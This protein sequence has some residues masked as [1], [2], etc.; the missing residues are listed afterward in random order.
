MEMKILILLLSLFL[1]HSEAQ[2]NYTV[3]EL[4]PSSLTSSKGYWQFNS[5]VYA[6]GTSSSSGS[7]LVS[8]SPSASSNALVWNQLS[9]P[10]IDSSKIS[11]PYFAKGDQFYFTDSTTRKPT[12][13][14]SSV[15][16][17]PDK[18][19][20][21]LR[22]GSLALFEGA[23]GNIK[24]R[25]GVATDVL[26]SDELA[27]T[28]GSSGEPKFV[29]GKTA[30]VWELNNGKF[31]MFHD[32]STWQ[33]SIAN[34]GDSFTVSW[35]RSPDFDNFSGACEKGTGEILSTSDSNGKP[36]L[37][38]PPQ[39]PVLFGRPNTGYVWFYDGLLW[40]FQNE[41]LTFAAPA[42]YFWSDSIGNVWLGQSLDS[43]NVHSFPLP[44]AIPVLDDVYVP[45]QWISCIGLSLDASSVFD[46]LGG[47]LTFTWYTPTN[48]YKGVSV[49]LPATATSFSLTLTVNGT[50]SNSKT[51]TV[52][53]SS[54]QSIMLY[55]GPP[56]I[57]S[58]SRDDNDEDEDV[59]HASFFNYKCDGSFSPISKPI[60][61]TSNG[62]IKF[63]TGATRMSSASGE[64]PVAV[65]PYV[66]FGSFFPV[67]DIQSFVA[68]YSSGSFY[69]RN[70]LLSSLSTPYPTYIPVTYIPSAYTRGFSFVI[71]YHDG[72]PSDL[73]PKFL[74]SSEV[75]DVNNDFFLA[76]YIQSK[77]GPIYIGMEDN[78]DLTFK[79]SSPQFPNLFD[80]SATFDD[81]FILYFLDGT[82]QEGQSYEFTC[83]V[84]GSVDSDADFVF[85]QTYHVNTAS[86]H[87]SG[88][89]SST[90]NPTN[91]GIQY[92][93]RVLQYFDL[94]SQVNQFL[95]FYISSKDDLSDAN[96]FLLSDGSSNS[97]EGIVPPSAQ[98]YVKVSASFGYFTV[99]KD[100]SSLE[101]TTPLDT[102]A[103]AT[104]IDTALANQ[105]VSKALQL[106]PVLLE[107]LAKDN[108]IELD[109]YDKTASQL[110]TLS[111][112]VNLT[113][114]SPERQ[115]YIYVVEKMYSTFTNTDAQLLIQLF[116][117]TLSSDT[118]VDR[119]TGQTVF[120]AL[121]E[122]IVGSDPNSNA[123]NSLYLSQTGVIFDPM[124]SILT[125]TI[126][127]QASKPT[128]SVPIYYSAKYISAQG[129]SYSVKS[130]K[131][132]TFQVPSSNKGEK[133]PS[134][135]LPT[136]LSRV[137]NLS[138]VYVQ[139]YSLSFNPFIYYVPTDI[140]YQGVIFTNV[141][142]LSLFNSNGTV[143]DTK[144]ANSEDSS[145]V[146]TIRIPIDTNVYPDAKNPN[147]IFF[148]LYWNPSE[149]KMGNDGMFPNLNPVLSSDGYINCTSNH[150]TNF[151]VAILPVGVV[152][153]KPKPNLG[154]LIGLPIAAAV[155]L[156]LVLAAAI[157]YVRRKSRIYKRRMRETE[158]LMAKNA[159][160]S[161]FQT[162]KP[163]AIQ[164][165][166]RIGG[167]AFGDVFKGIYLGTTEVALK[168]LSDGADTSEFEQEADMLQRLQ[169][170]NVTQFLGIWIT[171]PNPTAATPAERG[172]PEQY[173]VIEFMSKGSLL[174][175]LRDVTDRPTVD[176][177]LSMCQETAAG[178]NYLADRGVVHRDLAARNL[179]V[180]AEGRR[181]VVKVADFGMSRVTDDQALYES[182]S[183]KFP[184][185][186][187]SPEI[188]EYRKYSTKSDVWAF[189]IV[190][191]ELF[192]Y[193]KI[194][195]PEMTNAEASERVL[196][197]YRLPRP[198]TCPPEVYELMLKCWAQEA[199][200]RPSFA[201]LFRILS[202]LLVARGNLD[203]SDVEKQFVPV[204]AENDI[205]NNSA[206]A[207]EENA[208]AFTDRRDPN[209]TGSNI[210]NAKSG[211]QNVNISAGK[212]EDIYSFSND[213]V[214]NQ[215]A[216]TQVK[217]DD[218][219]SF[220][221]TANRSSVKPLGRE[222]D[223]YS[224]GDIASR[225]STTIP[226]KKDSEFVPVNSVQED[227]YNSEALPVP[228]QPKPANPKE[229]ADSMY[230][231]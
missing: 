156:A 10:T 169:H 152:S 81:S 70:A 178:M 140:N 217:Q 58:L 99:L 147:A 116:N 179:L 5:T 52:S 189:G 172:E 100:S 205:Y 37:Y 211:I 41:W 216:S 230:S 198:A 173:M 16:N 25:I 228:S 49:T 17:A 59:E 141:T 34:N 88:S 40:Q 150:L 29:S 61:L 108:N 231:L 9:S 72:I 155:L 64:V 184:V 26:F 91:L 31:L 126:R 22:D 148:C 120:R 105:Q 224:Y 27:L 82:F 96:A 128:E 163:D 56:T 180:R 215:R 214:D 194:P 65:S 219:Y 53:V 177:I 104:A 143:L 84:S 121:N 35:V 106:F 226:P 97:F 63:P 83:L 1:L 110:I 134:I 221:D 11:S 139:H 220:G 80:V 2:K 188:L 213:S 181:Y 133:R 79:W 44:S 124:E 145:A 222:E 137:G 51:W 42:A 114:N 174:S 176:G 195:Y 115:N 8:L 203:P 118:I 67:S 218:F 87:N 162:I 92:N 71:S 170:P 144:P 199:N 38:C 18:I 12:L 135:T 45:D 151:T 77:S 190:M 187:S 225:S 50:L 74:V 207:P 171:Y 164:I 167:G 68:E 186:W 229:E 57:L 107:S 197:G 60:R 66:G 185:K 46:P 160:T 101:A 24:V 129:G 3:K 20:A 117:F 75:V 127:S 113:A 94:Y 158:E 122:I 166:H 125:K 138:D 210:Y 130:L 204:S 201:E 136:D 193:G 21:S 90:T 93:G 36:F 123:G 119:K 19:L 73:S 168:K 85:A 208:Y 191:W 95:Y 131:G 62:T 7:F 175:V 103:I 161:N 39:D 23:D 4:V 102:S 206:L 132:K 182:K 212:G 183:N 111:S 98:I 209:S 192:E 13:L 196:Q 6:L 112:L 149:M 69:T 14:S 202:N 200:E 153:G 55:R 109:V 15:S 43:P 165:L 54:D 28:E 146:Y 223:I 33:F 157:F 78:S 30:L 32:L 154:L 89:L 227:I 159:S 47:N 48:S 86:L 76:S 142:A